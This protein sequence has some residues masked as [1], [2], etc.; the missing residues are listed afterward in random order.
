MLSAARAPADPRPTSRAGSAR[1]SGA[2]RSSSRCS[3]Q[4]AYATLSLRDRKKIHLA[5][6]ES[7]GPAD[8]LSPDHAAVLAQHLLDAIDALPGDDDVAELCGRRPS[9]SCAVPPTRARSSGCRTRPSSTSARRCATRTTRVARRRSARCWRGP[10][11]HRPVRGGR[12]RAAEQATRGLR[13]RRGRAGAP[14]C[15]LPRG[16]MASPSS[17]R[18]DEGNAG[19]QTAVGPAARRP[20]GDDHRPRAVRRRSSCH[21]AEPAVG[22]RHRPARSTS[23]RG[24]PRRPGDVTAPWPTRSR[25]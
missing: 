12:R 9:A 20:D 7:Y 11:R 18:P 13:R 23:G 8:D 10:H 15:P 17:G 19:G 14:G 22:H 6:V 1:S 16:R 3:A 5:I 4:V 21:R 25:G 2:T 24:S